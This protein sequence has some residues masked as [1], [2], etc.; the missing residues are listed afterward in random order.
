MEWIYVICRINYINV[1]MEKF[2]GRVRGTSPV[3]LFVMESLMEL[4]VNEMSIKEIYFYCCAMLAQRLEEEHFHLFGE[5]L[6]LTRKSSVNSSRFIS[7]GKMVSIRK[8]K[9]RSTCIQKVDCKGSPFTEDG[10]SRQEKLEMITA[11]PSSTE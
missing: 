6:V 7:N 1:Y 2:K 5:S 8:P 3:V 10:I 11:F 4:N 9:G